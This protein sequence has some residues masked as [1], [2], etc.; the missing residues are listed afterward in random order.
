MTQR[1]LYVLNIRPGAEAAYKR[2]HDEMPDELRELYRSAGMS[3][4]TVFL[5]GTQVIAYCEVDGDA[6]QAFAA[7]GDHPLEHA[8]TATLADVIVD[9]PDV[10]PPVPEVWRL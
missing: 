10:P 3:N 5:N 6:R 9:N 2:A 8:F 1:Y 7:V 4:Y